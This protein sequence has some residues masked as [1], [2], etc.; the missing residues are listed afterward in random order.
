MLPHH[1]IKVKIN[2]TGARGKGGEGGGK[3]TIS[4]VIEQKKGEAKGRGRR[5]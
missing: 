4:A 2:N 5:L 3:K 1:K